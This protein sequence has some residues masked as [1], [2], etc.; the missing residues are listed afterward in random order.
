[1]NQLDTFPSMLLAY[2][3]YSTNR[4]RIVEI[5]SK[6]EYNNF[7]GVQL[8]K[9]GKRCPVNQLIASNL[10]LESSSWA[11]AKEI[12]NTKLLVSLHSNHYNYANMEIF[13]ISQRG[14]ARKIYA[15][16]GA[17]GCNSDI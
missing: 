11:H 14:R 1:M 16:E 6:Q 8:P 4:I 13:D 5:E 12:A 9:R 3:S 7:P 15:F 17:Y 10:Y 2:C